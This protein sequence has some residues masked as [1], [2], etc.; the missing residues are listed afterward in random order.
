METATIL[1]TSWQLLWQSW[2]TI[3]NAFSTGWIST[4]LYKLKELSNLYC[5][6]SSNLFDTAYTAMYKAV[7]K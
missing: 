7:F 2:Q 5:E 1:S 4:S 3:Q 6:A